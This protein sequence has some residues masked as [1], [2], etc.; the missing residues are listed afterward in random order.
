MQP[1]SCVSRVV[2][3]NVKVVSC[4][5]VVSRICGSLPFVGDDGVEDLRGTDAEVAEDAEVEVCRVFGT[6]GPRDFQVFL[7]LCSFHFFPLCLSNF[8]FSKFI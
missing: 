6:L 8:I 7:H 3:Y 5:V 1:V 2:S 4:R